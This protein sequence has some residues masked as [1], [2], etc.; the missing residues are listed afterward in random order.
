MRY[1]CVTVL[2]TFLLPS[3]RLAQGKRARRLTA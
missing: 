3:S 2:A 1:V